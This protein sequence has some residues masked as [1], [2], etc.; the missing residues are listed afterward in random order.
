MK[1][2]AYISIANKFAKMIDDGIYKPGEKLPSIRSMHK[3]SGVSIGTILQSFNYLMDKDIVVSREKSGYYVNDNLAK[4]LPVPEVLP[5]S[6]SERTV[7]IDQLL[8]K[9]PVDRTGKDFVSFG[10]AVPDNRLLPFNS[11][12]R[13]IQQTSRDVS[14]SYLSLETRYG[15]KQLCEAIAKR[16]M[17]WQGPVHANEL[18]ITNGAAEAMVCCLKAVTQ[19]GDTVLVQE[20]CFFGIMQILELLGLKMA[21]IP[22]HPTTGIS[23]EN[24]K[25]A[26]RKLAIK[27]CVFV[28][29]FNNP[30]GASIST[31]QK[32]Q[33]AGLANTLQMPIIEDD[34]YGDLFFKGGRRDTIKAYDKDGWVMYCS[35]FTK[36]LAPGLRIGW[37]AAGRFTYDV[38]RI[39]AMMNHST[40]CFSQ[41]VILQLLTTGVLEKHLQKFRL[42]MQMNQHRYIAVIEKHFPAGTK[43]TQPGGGIYLWVELPDAVNTSVFLEKAFEHNI[44]Y[45]PGEIFSSKGK[46]LHYIR[47]SYS[48][49][50]EKKAE[51]ALIKLGKLL[52]E[53]IEKR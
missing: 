52:G 26:C 47:L 35:S 4:S 12:K 46:Y 36:T 31:D 23:V 33:I 9:M 21:T 41:R 39:K 28:S 42:E 15:N 53:H 8:Q 27:A 20:P 48:G 3:K 49:L 16:S 7:H 22:S 5:V 13:A 24:I 44:S 29:N 10:N 38:A 11:I 25:A 18:V 32:K 6:L 30:D 45:A 19:P 50:W 40:S 2:P 14:G 37:T 1:E 43:V 17:H 51:K 34:I